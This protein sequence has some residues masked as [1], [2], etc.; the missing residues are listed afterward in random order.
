MYLVPAVF[1]DIWHSTRSFMS[2]GRID[3]VDRLW[4]LGQLMRKELDKLVLRRVR[5][6]LV[7]RRQ[8][9]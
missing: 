5:V 6:F 1:D 8:E 3:R 2:P 9:S 4:I 7:G